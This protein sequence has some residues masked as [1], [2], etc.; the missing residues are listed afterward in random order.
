MSNHGLCICWRS[1]FQWYYPTKVGT[2]PFFF[3]FFFFPLSI[4]QTSLHRLTHAILLLPLPVHILHST[5]TLS[6]LYNSQS[7]L[8]HI[9]HELYAQSSTE[10]ANPTQCAIVF[11]YYYDCQLLILFHISKSSQI[12]G[13]SGGLCQSSVTISPRALAIAT[14]PSLPHM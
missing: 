4:N 11:N 13:S 9:I 5:T 8:N 6:A 12:R 1:I 14:R 3:F 10:R 7:T 2:L